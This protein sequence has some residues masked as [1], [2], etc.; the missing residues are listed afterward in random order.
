MICCLNALNQIFNAREA[1]MSA[2]GD[3]IGH[4]ANINEIAFCQP[5]SFPDQLHSASSDC[6]IRG[7]DVRSGSQTEQ[8]VHRSASRGISIGLALLIWS[9]LRRLI[10]HT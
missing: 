4:E 7:W 1:E 3:L 9:C 6:S 2:M 8:C 10:L 5:N